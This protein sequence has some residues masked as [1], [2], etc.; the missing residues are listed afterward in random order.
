MIALAPS[1]T[2]ISA[3]PLAASPSLPLFDSMTLSLTVTCWASIS[4]MPWMF[5][6]LITVL[7]AVTRM[8]RVRLPALVTSR[9][10]GHCDRSGPVLADAGQPQLARLAQSFAPPRRQ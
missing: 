4:S 3:V 2:L 5:S 9:C 1:S 7:A 10:P 8:V 6:Q